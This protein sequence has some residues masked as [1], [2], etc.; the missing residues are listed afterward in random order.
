[1]ININKKLDQY[2][3][4]SGLLKVVQQMEKRVP[5]GELRELYKVQESWLAKLGHWDEALVKYDKKLTENPRDGKA[6][7]GF[8]II[9][10]FQ[11][12]MIFK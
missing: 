8:Y 12:V 1:M 3:A 5:P 4:A 2:D 6:L 11:W 9:Y 7:A 10:Q